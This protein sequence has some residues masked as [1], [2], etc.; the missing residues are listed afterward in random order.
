MRVRTASDVQEGDRGDD[1]VRSGT[2]RIAATAGG[3][4]V[5]AR[6]GSRRQP[7]CHSAQ[8]SYSTAGSP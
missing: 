8:A 5:R 3:G 4:V 2:R 1:G 7:W 6:G